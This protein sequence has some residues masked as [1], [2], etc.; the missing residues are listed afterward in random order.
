MNKHGW[1]L[2]TKNAIKNISRALLGIWPPAYLALL[3][4]SQIINLKQK[5]IYE[6]VTTTNDSI[7]T[8]GIE[9]FRDHLLVY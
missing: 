4:I 7:G 6:E 9:S 3:C 8:Y 2:V 1:R 5:Y